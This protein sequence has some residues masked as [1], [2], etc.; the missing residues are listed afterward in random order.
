MIIALKLL[1]SPKVL[2]EL[3]MNCRSSPATEVKLVGV[4]EFVNDAILT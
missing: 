2:E 1:Y 4:V 3:R